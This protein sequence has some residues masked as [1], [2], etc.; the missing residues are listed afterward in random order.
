MKGFFENQEEDINPL[1]RK[2]HKSEKFQVFEPRKKEGD[3]ESPEL[4]PVTPCQCQMENS[5]MVFCNRHQCIKTKSLNHLCKTRMD[6]FEMWEKGEGPMQ[7]A[8]STMGLQAKRERI[9]EKAND[10]MI[11]DEQKGFFMGDP[12]IPS[13]SRGLGDT[14]A[15]ITKV[16]GIKK[17]VDTVFEAIN[18]DCGCREKQSTLNKL[19]PYKKEEGAKKKTK[20][21]FE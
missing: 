8:I 12:D 14:V 18:R 21:F 10:T 19:F 13:E 5:D 20:G 4:P 16:T 1:E 9:E 2:Y 6:Y 7:D 15:K 11:S 3:Y 17:A